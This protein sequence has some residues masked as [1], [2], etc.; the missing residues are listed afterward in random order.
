MDCTCEEAM[1]GENCVHE[2]A[3]AYAV[4]EHIATAEYEKLSVAED[5]EFEEF[6][7]NSYED[8][9][10]TKPGSS[11]KT[12]TVKKGRKESKKTGISSDIQLG[13]KRLYIDPK[14]YVRMRTAVIEDSD[15]AAFDNN[16]ARDDKGALLRND[17][18]E[19]QGQI[20]SAFTDEEASEENFVRERINIENIQSYHFL[21]D[22]KIFENMNIEQKVW[23]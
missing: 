17:I 16:S 13:D 15:K 19:L 20:L 2:A 5:D 12:H 22:S 9:A 1:S 14:G 6:A 18:P 7:L 23:K 8:E 4:E 3:L 21:D 11:V 10:I